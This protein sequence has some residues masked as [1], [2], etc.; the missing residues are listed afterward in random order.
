MYTWGLNNLGQL[1]DETNTNRNEPVFISCSNMEVGE[2]QLTGL[3]QIVPNPASN[4]LNMETLIDVTGI[5]IND[6]QGKTVIVRT[7]DLQQIDISGLS[8]GM[9]LMRVETE[10]QTVISKFIKR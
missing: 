8:A 1:G 3:I 6:M 5:T 7:E 2:S 10:K 9:Y 4:F